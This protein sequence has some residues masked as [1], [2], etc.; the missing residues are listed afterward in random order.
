MVE[1]TPSVG[2]Y[3]L[4][5]WT[6]ECL[7]GMREP[8]LRRQIQ[9]TWN[10]EL[11][12]L[13]NHKKDQELC[14]FYMKWGQ[15]ISASPQKM[16]YSHTSLMQSRGYGSTRLD[17]EMWMH[18]ETTEEDRDRAW[19]TYLCGPEPFYLEHEFERFDKIGVNVKPAK[20]S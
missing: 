16:T 14:G 1:V 20:R 17:M 9:R 5:P 11:Q 3:A 7:Y 15:H 19:S 18:G 13:V 4:S 12:R 8:D 2:K 10:L 6:C